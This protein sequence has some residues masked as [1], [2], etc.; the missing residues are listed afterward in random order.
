MPNFPPDPWMPRPSQPLPPELS[1]LVRTGDALVAAGHIQTLPQALRRLADDGID[2][3][4]Y[5]GCWRYHWR[6]AMMVAADVI[7]EYE[8]AD[9]AAP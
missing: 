5:E 7:E 6:C 2:R 1:D 3:T 9:E 4:H 8:N